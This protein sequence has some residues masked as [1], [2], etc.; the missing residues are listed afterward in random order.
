MWWRTAIAQSDE[1]TAYEKA[2]AP[3]ER[4]FFRESISFAGKSARAF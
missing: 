1:N 4:G 2:K 3:L